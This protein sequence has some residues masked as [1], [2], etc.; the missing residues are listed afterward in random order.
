V[1]AA[2]LAREARGAGIG[3]SSRLSRGAA[4]RHRLCLLG[5]VDRK[6]PLEDLA[7]KAQPGTAR[8]FDGGLKT[9]DR[10]SGGFAL[11]ISPGMP[12]TLLAVPPPSRWTAGPPAAAPDTRV[13]RSG[14]LLLT[15][16]IDVCKLARCRRGDALIYT[17]VDPVG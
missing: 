9:N 14:N 8:V 2:L 11:G 1:A 4:R 3:G 15:V 13:Y 17:E 5:K 10:N 6:H 16:R 7:R 12:A